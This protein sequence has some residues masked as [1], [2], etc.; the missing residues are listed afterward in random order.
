MHVKPYSSTDEMAY[1]GADELNWPRILELAGTIGG[2]EWYIIE[3]EQ[4]G[5]PP[6][7]ALKANY[8]IFQEMRAGRT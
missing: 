1:L 5:I 4:E 3:Y 2:I 7:E 6:L 8:D